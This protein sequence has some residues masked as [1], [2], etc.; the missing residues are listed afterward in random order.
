MNKFTKGAEGVLSPD[1]TKTRFTKG[2]HTITY[3]NEF[4]YFKIRDHE[5]NQNVG[6][7]G[8]PISSNSV[9]LKGPEARKYGKQQEHLKNTD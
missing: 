8:K 5:K 9:G 7:N 2:K 4:G 1:G 6:M 3:D